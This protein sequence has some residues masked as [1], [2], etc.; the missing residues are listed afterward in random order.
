V[1]QVSAEPHK[2]CPTMRG[3]PSLPRVHALNIKPGSPR[4]EVGHEADLILEEL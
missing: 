3:L 1:G 4:W 2:E